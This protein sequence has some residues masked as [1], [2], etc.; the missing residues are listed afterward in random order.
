MEEKV[1]CCGK[2]A[3]DS[4]KTFWDTRSKSFPGHREGDTYQAK[5][6]DT[7]KKHGVE[8]E[9]KTVL[10]LGC[11]TGSYTI[12]M[13]RE[14]AHVTALDISEGMLKTL[15]ESARAN[16]L[17][18]ITCVCADWAQYTPD[19][20][21][22]LIF[23][24]LTPAVQDRAAVEKI[25]K[26]AAG[27]VVNISFAGPMKAYVLDGLFK[28]HGH[29]HKRGAW[30]PVM[31]DWL[32]ENNIHFDSCRV[33]GEWVTERSRED[34]LANCV[35]VLEAHK[36]TPDMRAL[37]KFIEQFWDA[38][39]KMYLSRTAYDVEMTIWENKR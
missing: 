20:K 31:R 33:Q 13:A 7:M 23:C 37:E 2:T 30:E 6:L 9:G 12:R 28:L 24:S 14:A 39:S 11:G 36:I 29:E 35:D 32:S 8:L 18:N 19:R 25:R 3:E 38:E 15:A 1:S 16:N 22:D 27:W 17:T 26:H 4:K 10:D 5:M 21:F 34:M